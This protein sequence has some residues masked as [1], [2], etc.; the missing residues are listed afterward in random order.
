[1]AVEQGYHAGSEFSAPES[2]VRPGCQK[3]KIFFM[4]LLYACIQ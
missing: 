4:L 1:M 3:P 2:K